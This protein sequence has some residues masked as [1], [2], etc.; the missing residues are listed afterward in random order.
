[1]KSKTSTAK[2][3]L[4]AV[5]TAI[6]IV[7]QLLGAFIKFGPFSVSLVLIPIV[8]GSALCGIGTGAFLGFVFG[9]VVLLSGD[10]GLF[11]AVNPLGTV[12]VVLLK[13]TSCG[14]VAGVIYKMFCKK[15]GLWAVFLS[16]I[17]CPVTN[18]AIFL[19]GCRIFF[20][21]K[22]SSWATTAG[23]A[24]NTAGYI[25]ATLVGFNFLFEI[26]VNALLSPVIVRLI[27]TKRGA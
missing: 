3:V 6:V 15:S 7:L 5:L 23:F 4:G 16:A 22:I 21:D 26:L 1:M 27:N 9:L 17:A 24:G 2:M 11:L 18:T 20:M 14:V 19:I 10:A 13:G 25:I 8:I 12:L